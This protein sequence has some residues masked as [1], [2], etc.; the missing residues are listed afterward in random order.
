[1]Q[2]ITRRYL[3]AAVLAAAVENLEARGILIDEEKVLIPLLLE[4]P[5]RL[6]LFSWDCGY[7]TFSV[8]LWDGWDW[9]GQD[10]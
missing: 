10:E 8:V 9:E 4:P 2:N 3:F 7:E 5:Q 1:M 6:L